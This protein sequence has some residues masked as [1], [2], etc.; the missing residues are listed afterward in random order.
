MIF[1]TNGRVFL[2]NVKLVDDI[3][4]AL[5]HAYLVMPSNVWVMIWTVLAMIWTVLEMVNDLVRK[6]V[7][8]ETEAEERH[9]DM[10]KTASVSLAALSMDLFELA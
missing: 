6:L 4:K 5:L 7:V 9:A 1:E 3:L 10:T 2:I 8:I